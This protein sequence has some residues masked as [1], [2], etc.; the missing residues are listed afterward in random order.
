MIP[1][2]I[3]HIYNTFSTTLSFS[4]SLNNTPDSHLKNLL[5]NLTK[6]KGKS[7]DDIYI[8]FSKLYQEQKIN[9]PEQAKQLAENSYI[10]IIQE[11]SGNYF[12]K[13]SIIKLTIG[14]NQQQ[15]STEIKL[16]SEIHSKHNHFT[17]PK[18]N[19]KISNLGW[20]V[21]NFNLNT[22]KEANSIIDSVEPLLQFAATCKVATIAQIDK[23]FRGDSAL[24]AYKNHNGRYDNYG[25]PCIEKLKDAE[26]Q[27]KT[28]NITVTTEIETEKTTYPRQEVF[29][30]EYTAN[31]KSIRELAKSIKIICPKTGEKTIISMQGELL[32][33][34]HTAIIYQ[35]LGYNVSIKQV[36]NYNSFKDTILQSLTHKSQKVQTFFSVS[37]RKRE[38]GDVFIKKNPK[39][40]YE[41][42]GEITGYDKQTDKCR[43]TH[44]G[45]HY[46]QS[47]NNLYTSSKNL[48]IT[49]SQEYYR[50]KDAQ[51][52]DGAWK[53]QQQL[54]LNEG[55]KTHLIT[56]TPE[57]NTGFYDK[58]FT[59]SLKD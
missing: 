10:E 58:I 45:N 25:L 13:Y 47:T 2:F 3:S 33:Y 24:P 55:G 41:H 28:Q 43:V 48:A 27:I 31:A 26:K 18:F 12:D 42:T 4:N 56:G 7:I 39:E 15:E 50:I 22:L 8:Q 52:N 32:D 17:K 20:N 1:S 14:N 16:D 44:W 49:R 6:V 30:I 36:N 54:K 21:L 34:R 29:S 40:M 38:H 19:F 53:L 57:F 37:T 51:P 59:I 5:N 23:G 35:L 46:W 9:S 11:K